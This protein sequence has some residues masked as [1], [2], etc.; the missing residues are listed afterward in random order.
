MFIADAV[1]TPQF[2]EGAAAYGQAKG[3]SL[4]NDVPQSVI[5]TLIDV[6]LEA[7]SFDLTVQEDENAIIEGS[8][9]PAYMSALFVRDAMASVEFRIACT[10]FA[11]SLVAGHPSA[12]VNEPSIQPAANTNSDQEAA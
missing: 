3:W 11:H 5:L 1:K 12:K 9:T 2:G 10:E 8:V 6:D 7:G 4:R